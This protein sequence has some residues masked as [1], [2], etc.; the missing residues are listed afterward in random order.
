MYGVW[1][2]VLTA[3]VTVTATACASG[4]DQPQASGATVPTEATTTT[5][6]SVEQEVEQAYLKSWDVYVKAVRDLDTSRLAEAYAGEALELKV[7]E[8]ERLRAA[9]TPVRYEVEHDYDIRLET[10]TRAVVVDRQLNH[11][12]LLNM[13][14]EPLEPDPN[15]VVKYEFVMEKRGETWFVLNVF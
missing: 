6:L 14:G 4:N 12:V 13:K 11:A 3:L 1:R 10:P 9:Q 5:T 2:W 8:V 7:N 15:E